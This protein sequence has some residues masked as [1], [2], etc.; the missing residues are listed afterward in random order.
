MRRGKRIASLF[1]ALVL[2]GI[3]YRVL[4]VYEFRSGECSS[5]AP[6]AFAATYPKRLVVMAYNIEGHAS[7]LDAD[8]IAGIAAVIN[9]YRPDLVALN[10]THRGTWQAR[11]GDHTRELARRTGMSV[12][13]GRSYRFA[14][15][16]FG[17]AV[18][19]RGTIAAAEVYKLPGTG[20]PRSLLETRVR[21]NGG[22]V[23][24]YVTHL[25]A[26][27]SL[28][29]KTRDLQL[30]CVAD[31]VRASAHPFLLAGDLNAP[32]ESAEVAKFLRAAPLVL[33]GEP[34]AATHRVMEQRL[35][36]ILA[37]RGWRVRDARVLDEG[38]SDHRP[39]LAELVHE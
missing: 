34:N 35:D 22:V 4:G 37:D 24:L 31:H 5:P 32:P 16:D 6:R 14:G 10:E 13:F 7:L 38:P 2:L 21:V 9:R 20:E 18:L 12:V 17:N 39:I 8:H 30:Q 23:E 26:W 33:A 15:G 3:A 28:G 11:F 29:R 1:A 36:Y 19:A 27:S 25:A